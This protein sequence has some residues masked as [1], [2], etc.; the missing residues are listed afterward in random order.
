ML[1]MPC[2]TFSV[3]EATSLSTRS[4]S[5]VIAAENSRRFAIVAST[6]PRL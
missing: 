6:L 5:L 3:F 4:T 1:A 2:V